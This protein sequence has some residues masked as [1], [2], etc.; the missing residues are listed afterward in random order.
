MMCWWA[1]WAPSS[2]FPLFTVCSHLENQ[3]KWN[4]G[5]SSNQSIQSSSLVGICGG[6]MLAVGDISQDHILAILAS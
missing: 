4:T 2:V 3:D 1:A 6:E 5:L